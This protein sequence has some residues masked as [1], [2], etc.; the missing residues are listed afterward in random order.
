MPL[1]RLLGVASLL[2]TLGSAADVPPPTEVPTPAPPGSSS[3]QLT[4]TPEGHA[5][6]SWLEPAGDGKH[7]FRFSVRKGS[8]WSEPVTIAEE[9]RVFANWADV[10]AIGI[11]PDGTWAANWL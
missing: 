9:P 2:F 10:P 5:V 1:L 7:R 11:M 8:T 3:P 6:L 4:T